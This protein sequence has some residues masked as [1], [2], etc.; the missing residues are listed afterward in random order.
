MGTAVAAL[1]A[2]A[3]AV[4][5]MANHV[6]VLLLGEAEL[7]NASLA[8]VLNG[9]NVALLGGEILQFMS[10]ELLG[11]GRYRLSGLLR[12][13]LGTEHAMETHMAGE[14]FVLLNGLVEA[15]PMAQNSIGLTRLYKPVT[16]G[17]SLATTDAVG[18]AYAGR[19]WQPYSPVHVTAERAV[20][21]DMSLRWVRRTRI[22]GAWRDF[23]DA[24]LSET[25]ERYEVEVMDGE[26]VKR[27]LAADAPEAAYSAAQQEAD[28]GAVQPELAVRIY[29]ISDVV[30]RGVP[31]EA[32]V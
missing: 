14:R 23:V 25:A 27:V 31:A 24:L 11:E 32:V 5:D 1:D 16:V 7:E 28:F 4:P 3:Y 20:N 22:G 19:P 17:Q 10:A 8:A 15:I 18:V 30:G 2:G 12:G 13:R 21:G 26:G 9:A 29:Q 6:E